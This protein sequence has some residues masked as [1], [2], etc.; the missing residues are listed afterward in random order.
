MCVCCAVTLS[1]PAL[2]HCTHPFLASHTHLLVLVVLPHANLEHGHP[3][4]R[5][6]KMRSDCTSRVPHCPQA[7]QKQNEKKEGT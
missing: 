6:A 4:H 5:R 1:S 7:D 3:V 2:L